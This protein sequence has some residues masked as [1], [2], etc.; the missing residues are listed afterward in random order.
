MPLLSDILAVLTPQFFSRSLAAASALFYFTGLIWFFG[1]SRKQ[2]STKRL[3][4]LTLAI[5]LAIVFFKWAELLGSES[6]SI[7]TSLPTPTLIE[8]MQ[9]FSLDA[10]YDSLLEPLPGVS[11]A[12]TRLTIWYK[13]LL[14]SSA[15]I[16]GGAILYDILAG[17]SPELRLFF[18]GRR[19]LMVFSELNEKSVL[20]A[21]SLAE[22][23]PGSRPFA[24]VFTDCYPLGDEEGSELLMRAKDLRAVCLQSDL[25][26]CRGF[27]RSAFCSFF[28]MDQDEA[29]SLDD[30]SNL[31]ALKGLLQREAPVW[32]PKRGCSVTLF[33]NSIE[34][35]EN[36]RAMKKAFEE[37]SDSPVQVH[38]IRDLD[39]ACCLH[40]NK[41]PLYVDLP[42]PPKKKDA[43]SAE[44]KDAEPAE[45]KDAKPNETL[46]VVIFGRTPFALE[47][48]RSVFWCG[49]I[50][51]HPLRI[52][53]VAPPDEG[54][55]DK[56]P[57]LLELL[58]SNPELLDSC[59]LG[60]KCLSTG[61]GDK[62]GDIY[63]SLCFVTD[64]PARV[65]MRELLT[66]SRECEYGNK[67]SFCLKDAQRFFVMTGSDEE[68]VALADELR[69]A[70]VY[71]ESEGT[72]RGKKTISAAV[73]NGE[74][75]EVVR[76]RFEVYSKQDKRSSW[77]KTHLFGSL[78]DR[79]CC[80]II[81]FD[82]A[83]LAG[84]EELRKMDLS[85]HSLPDIGATSDD[86]YNEWSRV[87]RAYHQ[88]YKMYS[89]GAEGETEAKKKLDYVRK[90]REAAAAERSFAK[91]W[92]SSHD[93]T[94]EE[95]DREK[96][97]LIQDLRWLEHRRW[98]AF[99]RAEGFSR[100]AELEKKLIQDYDPA[101]RDEFW[102]YA[103]KNVPSRLHPC[104]TECP[105]DPTGVTKPDL[106]DLVDLLREKMD[107][108][109]D[110]KPVL[111]PKVSKTKSY[112][113]PG[114]SNSPTVTRTELRE[115]WAELM[116]T[117]PLKSFRY[118][119][120][121]ADAWLSLHPDLKQSSPNSGFYY[122]DL[123]LDQLEKDNKETED[124][125]KK[126]IE[127]CKDKSKDQK[128]KTKKLRK[129]FSEL[130]A[131]GKCHRAKEK[132]REAAAAF[133]ES[134]KAFLEKC[135]RLVDW[136]GLFGD[137]KV[138]KKRKRL[139]VKFKKRKTKYEKREK[140]FKEFLA[141][142]LT[143]DTEKGQ[144]KRPMIIRKK[145]AP[146]VTAFCLGEGSDLEKK[147]IEKGQLIRREDGSFEVRTRESG[148]NP[149]E[150]A[151]AG[152]YVKLDAGG[153]PYP[154][155]KETFEREHRLTAEGYRQIPRLLQAWA[156]GETPPPALCW[157]LEEGR[158]QLDPQDPEHFYQAELWGTKLS[159]PWDAVLVFYQIT[160]GEDG[161]I[162]DVDF[163]FVVREIFDQSYE[164]LSRD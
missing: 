100:P 116:E 31:V 9:S 150:A 136:F 152:D 34:T 126:A 84:V 32:R 58:R 11:G 4:V 124:S 162:Q 154:V 119:S 20:L 149:G 109:E 72:V 29:G 159:A 21:E 14:F 129:V 160:T 65:P 117:F 125:C 17:I 157:L 1:L 79:F 42:E 30:Q 6:F 40:L 76:K 49:Q 12:W 10:N 78:A 26:H 2:R 5:V 77:L 161:Q 13:V 82:S 66:K 107:W 70:L 44:K 156:V 87:A 128:A 135:K 121:S 39:T 35:I 102:P 33:T 38:V 56:S 134:C 139:K 71:L 47:M 85:R 132:A 51:D 164:I 46:D 89:A 92:E 36:I 127:E 23:K 27:R 91:K 158:L 60:G 54:A 122:L 96:L 145:E 55:G 7:C 62:R 155:S 104:L 64:D 123:I 101:K 61:L 143:S 25:L 24:I 63:A 69:R 68:N 67:A 19:R 50:L 110:P 88:Q 137:R 138:Q 146:P 112:D 43:E 151:R 74:L 148:E 113:S 141:H 142:L 95:Q 73:E 81:S 103:R 98:C 15:P 99:L 59:T 140:E 94:P 114:G 53:V 48:F 131:K 57:I 8:T 18:L 118:G 93:A 105:R 45:K 130:R 111:W 37:I 86:I 3:L 22:K 97:K 75:A 120:F 133:K 163:N 52:T 16:V 90:T 153:F 106:L 41:V 80:E 28:L 83:D 144:H 108:K 115:L 147:L